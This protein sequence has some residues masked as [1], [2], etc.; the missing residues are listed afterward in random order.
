MRWVSEPRE[1]TGKRTMLHN[2]T[3]FA[4]QRRPQRDGIATMILPILIARLWG[5]RC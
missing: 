5:G 2:G 3:A 4:I 1:A